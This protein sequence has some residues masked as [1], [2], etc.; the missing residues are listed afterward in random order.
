MSLASN[1]DRAVVDGF[2]DEWS[3]FDQ[4]ALASHEH[5][6][7]FDTYFAIFPWASLPAGAVGADF[8]CGSGRWARLVAPRVGKLHC[9]DASAAALDVARRALASVHNVQ[10]HQASIGALPLEDESLDF[11]YSLGVLHH[12]PDPQAGLDACVRTLKVGA[13]FLVYLYYAF[14]NRPR[15]FRAVWR[16]SDVLR[17]GISRLPYGP[18]YLLSQIIAVAVYWPLARTAR[19]LERLGVA[20]STLPLSAYRDRSLYSMRTDALDRFG[21]RLEK[22]FTRDEIAR[23]MARAGLADV[24]FH[25]G[26]AFWC[27]VGRKTKQGPGEDQRSVFQL[28]TAD[29][30]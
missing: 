13:P 24:R 1:L 10:F 22:R 23:M 15:W 4:L 8:G 27:A 26:G 5:Q 7:L 28:S 17:R 6:T 2:G 9:V 20:V 16:A 29:D 18:R 30:E 11:G 14:D 25:A 21:T 12:L 19:L 3:R